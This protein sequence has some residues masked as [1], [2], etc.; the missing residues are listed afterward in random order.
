MSIQSIAE[1]LLFAAFLLIYLSHLPIMAVMAGKM[2]F[3]DAR[4]NLYAVLS[5][6]P[7]LVS[8]L[9][10]LLGPQD[11]GGRVALSN[12]LPVIFILFVADWLF[13]TVFLFVGVRNLEKG[14]KVRAQVSA[15]VSLVLSC[16]AA[17]GAGFATV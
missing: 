11:L 3:R 17:V 12:F 13:C 8:G 7:F 5:L 15:T 4:L 6:L 2:G 9:L 1:M 10:L 14:S 16:A